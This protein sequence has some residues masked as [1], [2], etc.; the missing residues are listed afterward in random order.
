M[1]AGGVYVAIHYLPGPEPSSAKVAAPEVRPKVNVVHPRRAKLAQRLVSNATLEA[2]EETDLF[3]K[4]SGYLSEVRVDIVLSQTTWYLQSQ[5]VWL[6]ACTLPS[7]QSTPETP[8]SHPP[9]G[10]GFPDPLSGTLNPN[11]RQ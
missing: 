7:N 4:V 2:L 9:K 5:T 3:A 11:P 8:R 10:V 6:H 1:V